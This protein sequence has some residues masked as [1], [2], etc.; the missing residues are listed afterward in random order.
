MIELNDFDKE[1]AYQLLRQLVAIR[2]YPGEEAAAQQACAAWL[3]Q[4]NIASTMQPTRNGQPNV[5]ARIENGPGP[6]LMLNGHM[7][8][9]LRA[10]GWLHDPWQG[11]REGDIFYGLGAADMKCGVAANMLVARTLAHN[12][13]A[14]R[15]TLI[16]TSVTD[17]EA[18]SHGARA[19]VDGTPNG[20]TA[21]A[22][23]VSEPLSNGGAIGAAGKMLVQV[24][25]TGKAAH[26][27][28]PWQGINAGIEAARFA[29]GVCNAVPELKHPQVPSSQ[30]VLSIHAGS[31]QYVITLPEKARVLLT[32]QIVPGETREAV[33]GKMQAF[34][35]SLQSPA[36]FAFSNP[37]PYYAP[38]AFDEPNHALTQAFQAAYQA[39]Y[40]NAPNLHYM[41]GISD[42]NVFRGEAG[43]PSIVHGP[44]GDNFHQCQEW[45]DLASIPAFCRVALGV[46]L[47][48]L[49]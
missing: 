25:V 13:Q 6:T 49:Q 15:G 28:L 9:V 14:W 22:C 48:F 18:Y 36:Q 43:I 35:N 3:A 11:W 26:G 39:E 34:A 2:S 10:E 37:D 30:T 16:F 19:L 4:Y 46:A 21:D 7:D 32:R 31:E 40:G 38:W 17:E 1:E 47:R 45:V 12:K 23:L 41:L 27:F 8:T 42:A 44:H 29:A 33:L 20:I 24:D 5:I